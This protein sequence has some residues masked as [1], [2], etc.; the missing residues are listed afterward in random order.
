[1][2]H[3]LFD[4]ISQ[5]NVVSWTAMIAGYAQNGVF[6]VSLRFFKEIPPPDVISCRS[7]GERYAQNRICPK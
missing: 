3:D 7:M 1:M 4:K 5:T 6:D 2:E